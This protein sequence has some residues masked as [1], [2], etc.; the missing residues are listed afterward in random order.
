MIAPWICVLISISMF[1]LGAVMGIA[2]YVWGKKCE[3]DS[4]K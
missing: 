4:S 2:G 3:E 1:I